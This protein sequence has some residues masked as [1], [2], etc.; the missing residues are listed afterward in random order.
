MG[1]SV[2]DFG[3]FGYSCTL[4]HWLSVVDIHGCRLNGLI[5]LAIYYFLHLDYLL[6][7]VCCCLLKDYNGLSKLIISTGD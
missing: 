3:K 1:P 4:N 5:V 2:V 6:I 7:A